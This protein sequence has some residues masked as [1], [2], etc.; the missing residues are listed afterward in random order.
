MQQN[1]PS[2]DSS[3]QVA[4][5]IPSFAQGIVPSPDPSSERE[6]PFGGLALPARAPLSAQVE[7][8]ARENSQAATTVPSSSVTLGAVVKTA[9]NSSAVWSGVGAA[10]VCLDSSLVGVLGHGLSTLWTLRNDVREKFG[11]A[12]KNGVKADVLGRPGYVGLALDALRSPAFNEIAAGL[13]YLAAAVEAGT[14]GRVLEAAVFSVYFVGAMTIVDVLNQSYH[15]TRSTLTMLERAFKAAWRA[16]PTRVQNLLKD[17]GVYLTLGNGSLVIGTMSFQNVSSDPL[18]T[19]ALGVGL[20]LSSLG[21]VQSVVNFC[22]GTESS[23]EQAGSVYLN[24][25]ANGLFG[26]A[27]FLQGSPVVGAA[28]MCW[29]ISCVLLGRMMTPPQRQP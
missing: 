4:P 7:E 14:R 20:A 3:R 6:K 29:A 28:K 13:T 2:R 15:G 5:V 9:F 21:L 25:A 17:P 22:R 19:V 1:F 26:V 18:P 11:G 10:V 16:L 23:K 24:G 12:E 8:T 27:S